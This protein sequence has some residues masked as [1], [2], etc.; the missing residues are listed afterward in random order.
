MEY[1]V[2]KPFTT[3]NRRFSPATTPKVRAD[4]LAESVVPVEA[5][6]AKGFIGP[7]AAA[8]AP[9]ADEAPLPKRKTAAA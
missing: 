9:A 6:M 8:P 3:V 1:A 4:E 5:Y 2:L 7:V